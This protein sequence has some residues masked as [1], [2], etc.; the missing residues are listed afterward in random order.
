L[1]GSGAAWD[2]IGNVYVD[3]E[4]GTPNFGTLPAFWPAEVHDV[5]ARL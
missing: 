1:E 3:D 4:T 2:W 5:K